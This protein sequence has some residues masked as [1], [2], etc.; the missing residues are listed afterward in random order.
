[1]QRKRAVPLAVARRL[2]QKVAPRPIHEIED[3]QM[4]AGRNAFERGGVAR[5][6]LDRAYRVGAARVLRAFVAPRPGRADAADEIDPGVEFFRQRGRDLA[7][8]DIFLAH[9][10]TLP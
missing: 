2:H 6:E 9:A 10:I 5:I 3:D 1:S 4:R 8:T 7:G